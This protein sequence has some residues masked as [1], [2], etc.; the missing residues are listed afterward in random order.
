M[1]GLLRTLL[2][3]LLAAASAARLLAAPP[4][5]PCFRPGLPPTLDGALADDP[6]WE[7]VPVATGFSKLGAGYTE[8][9][10]TEVRACWDTEALY[11]GLLCEEPDVASMKP[12]VRDGG[13]TWLDDGVEVFLQPA[14]DATVVQFVVTAAGAKGGYEGAPDF[15][16]YQ[17]AAHVGRDFYSLEL[18]IPFALLGASPTI[19]DTWRGNFCRNI[20]TTG[21]GGDR[22][23][24]WAPLEARFLEPERFAAIEFLGPPDLVRASQLTEQLN[25]PYRRDLARRLRAVAATAPE[26]TPT[27][28]EAANDE[29]FGEPA[30]DLLARWEQIAEVVREADRAPVVELR[31]LVRGVQALTQHS[32]DVKYAYLIAQ[33]LRD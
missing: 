30:R 8:A 4:A 33:L 24:C 5:Y 2:A 19:G 9:K 31:G 27:L 26:Y 7:G 32:Y 15:L 6:A 11:V 3:C 22:F 21:S 18:R 23:T 13:D 25:R 16:K 10:Q 1:P 28:A 17:A 20:W 14:P 12:T 29:R